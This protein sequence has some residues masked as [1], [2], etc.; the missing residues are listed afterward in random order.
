MKIAMLNCLNANQVCTGAGCLRAFNSRTKHFAEYGD[1]PLELVS[2]A[3][4]NGCGKGIDEGFRE[5]LDRIVSE[6]AETC[7]LGV[8]TVRKDLGR[9]CPVITEAAAYLEQ[10]GVRPVRGTH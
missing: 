1:I 5:K 10:R 4:C 3:R 6:G 8:C 2:M 9:E 7:H